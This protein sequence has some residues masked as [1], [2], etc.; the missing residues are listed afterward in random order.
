VAFGA[1]VAGEECID[2]GTWKKTALIISFGQLQKSIVPVG[3]TRS[4]S[5]LLPMA[6][7]KIMG[8]KGD[9]RAEIFAIDE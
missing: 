2:L 3:S 5:P 7:M 6:E 4:G 1:H 8:P 9:N